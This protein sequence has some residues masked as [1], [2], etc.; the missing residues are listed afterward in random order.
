M[1]IAV[2]WCTISLAYLI[3]CLNLTIFEILFNSHILKLVFSKANNTLTY[4][5]VSLSLTVMYPVSLPLKRN[6]VISP[7][8]SILPSLLSTF[9]TPFLSLCFVRSCLVQSF[10]MWSTYSTD[11]RCYKGL[12]FRMS[13]CGD[14][15]IGRLLN[16]LKMEAY[17]V[18][19]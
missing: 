16:K 13:Q 9:C 4:K 14:A 2:V 12:Y 11:F 10:F 15:H 6:K 19:I 7:L 8:I 5:I 3:A 17:W 18:V 1:A